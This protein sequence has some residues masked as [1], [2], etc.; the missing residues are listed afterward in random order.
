MLTG[1]APL[2]L[3]DARDVQEAQHIILAE[4]PQAPGKHN[5]E[6]PPWLDSVVLCALQK[7]PRFRFDSIDEM[8]AALEAQE[9]VAL[10]QAAAESEAEDDALHRG[11]AATAKSQKR[12]QHRREVLFDVFK[13]AVL[14]AASGLV[15]GI[16]TYG[17]RVALVGLPQVLREG[18]PAALMLTVVVAA[19]VG[20]VIGWLAQSSE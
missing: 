2:D 19:G 7:Y 12:W 15:L 17:V 6:I 16:L 1:R 20:A 14:G 13:G 18:A 9:F 8:R 3:H 5:A 11:L 10:P 4:P